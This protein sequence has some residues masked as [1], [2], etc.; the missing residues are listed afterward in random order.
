MRYREADD[1]ACPETF[2]VSLTV[3]NVPW[4]TKQLSGFW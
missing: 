2:K 1:Q 3:D 4:L